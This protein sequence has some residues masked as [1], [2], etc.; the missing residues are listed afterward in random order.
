MKWDRRLHRKMPKEN[1]LKIWN[2]IK[3]LY[4]SMLLLS[5]A[6]FKRM[7]RK[8][9]PAVN[10]SRN[11]RGKKFCFAVVVVLISVSSDWRRWKATREEG[12]EKN[13]SLSWRLKIWSRISHTTSE[14]TIQTKHLRFFFLD[15]FSGT[16]FEMRLQS[17]DG[18]RAKEKIQF[19]HF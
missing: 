2:Q 11:S 10:Q 8:R 5:G 19:D 7:M 3:S 12:E 6:S 9:T 15:S 13:V 4:L 1:A 16:D 18:E 14:K 17:F